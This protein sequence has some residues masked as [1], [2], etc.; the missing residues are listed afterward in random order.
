MTLVGIHSKDGYIFIKGAKGKKDR[1]TLLSEH[2]VELLRRYYREHKPAYW[3]FEGQ[4]GGKYSPASVQKVFRRDQQAS[5]VN[6]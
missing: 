5:G 2:L 6:P 1:R 4:A 3:L